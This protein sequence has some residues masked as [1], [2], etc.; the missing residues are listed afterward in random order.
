M[1]TICQWILSKLFVLVFKTI[2]FL[3]ETKVN[4]HAVADP[5]GPGLEPPFLTINVF[6]W[7]HM[8][9]LPHFSCVK[10]HL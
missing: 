5:G 3:D 7:G 8:V 10:L 4:I 1:I 2:A 9:P 6:D